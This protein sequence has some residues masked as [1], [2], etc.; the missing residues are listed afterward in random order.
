[1]K[2]LA[3]ILNCGKASIT[4][5][6]AVVLEHPTNWDNVSWND[7]KAGIML[8]EELTEHSNSDQHVHTNV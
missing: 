6:Y 5:D 8:K 7:T 4:V 3:V 2:T 1:M